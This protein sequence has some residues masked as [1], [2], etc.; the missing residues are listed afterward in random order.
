[1]NHLKRVQSHLRLFVWLGFW[2]PIN[3]KSVTNISGLILLPLPSLA[4]YS[5]NFQGTPSIPTSC[6]FPKYSAKFVALSPKLCATIKSF[7][8]RHS[9]STV[10]AI[11][12]LQAPPFPTR[13]GFKFCVSSER[14]GNNNFIHINSFVFL[15][16]KRGKVALEF[17][18]GICIRPSLF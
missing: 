14:T 3:S 16:R 15:H 8:C 1:M 12:N 7:C 2:P 10:Y 5:R 9:H 18:K 13:Q 4:S 17:K 11:E 6:A